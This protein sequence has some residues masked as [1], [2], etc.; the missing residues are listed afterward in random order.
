MA[1]IGE[2]NPHARP[3]RRESTDAERRLWYRLRNRNLGGFKFRRQA[4]IGPF[5]A[6]FACAD[7]KLIV[8]ADG[9]Q[10]DDSRDRPRTA[11]LEALGWKV[12]RF[13]NNDILQQTDAVLGD[14][15]AACEESREAKPSPT[16]LPRAGEG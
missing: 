11:Y 10:H 3:L 15:L 16:P 7:L 8:E 2:S 14:I 5:I 4:T 1:T 13:W 6:D 12:L 9:G